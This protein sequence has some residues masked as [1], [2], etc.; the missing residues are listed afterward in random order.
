MGPVAMVAT[1]TL[2]YRL[3]V[4]ATAV[5]LWTWGAGAAIGVEQL[6]RLWSERGAPKDEG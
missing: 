2:D 5:I 1:I 6:R 4:P 3:A